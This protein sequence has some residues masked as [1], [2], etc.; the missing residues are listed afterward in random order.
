MLWSYSKLKSSMLSCLCIQGVPAYSFF[1]IYGTNLSKQGLHRR[2][3]GAEEMSRWGT[4]LSSLR[5]VSNEGVIYLR[6]FHHEPLTVIWC[7]LNIYYRDCGVILLYLIGTK[8]IVG[9][10]ELYKDNVQLTSKCSEFLSHF[11]TTDSSTYLT[12]PH[13]V[14]ESFRQYLWY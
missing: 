8:T 2:I 5:A 1:N 7:K 9:I 6:N 11:C 12:S 4:E 14:Y 3:S 13:R 10:V